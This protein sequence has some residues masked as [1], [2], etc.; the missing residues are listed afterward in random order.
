MGAIPRLVVL[1]GS[2]ALGIQ[3]SAVSILD[4]L[5]KEDAAKTALLKEKKAI[6]ALIALLELSREKVIV[7]ACS[8]L[9]RIVAKNRNTNELK[10]IYLLTSLYS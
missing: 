4:T 5:I 1:L 9:D 3:E 8:C 6:A 10:L 2:T 7:R